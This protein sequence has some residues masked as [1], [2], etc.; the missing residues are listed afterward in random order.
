MRE[1]TS[2]EVTHLMRYAYV[3]IKPPERWAQGFLAYD[4]FGRHVLPNSPVA[5]KFSVR[6][7]INYALSR[8]GW[9]GMPGDPEEGMVVRHLLTA[10]NPD[11]PRSFLD[12]VWG[13]SSAQL[14]ALFDTY[15][16]KHTHPVICAW[17]KAAVERRRSFEQPLPMRGAR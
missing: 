2:A 16:D 5:L 14:C 3:L 10:G 6:G 12:I 13:G 9:R 7:S 15:N 1:I 8:C 11:M 4:R 17:M